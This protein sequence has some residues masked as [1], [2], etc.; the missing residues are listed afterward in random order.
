MS[1]RL[2]AFL[3]AAAAASGQTTH[4]NLNAVLW[5][6]TAAEKR[7]GAVQTYRAAERQLFAAL[8]DPNWTAALEQTGDYQKLPPAVILDLDETVLDNSAIMARFVLEKSAFNEAVWTAWVNERRAPAVP[9]AVDF[10][11]VAHANGVA[12]FYVTN[13]VCDPTKA[14]DPTADVLRALSLPFSPHR[15]FCKT[16]ATDKSARRQRIAGSHR[17]LL[18]IGDDLNDFVSLPPEPATIEARRT[19]AAAHDRY[20]GDRWFVLPNPMYGSW[21][22]AV[23]IEVSKKLEALRP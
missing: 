10:I 7:A 9:G 4:E 11:K 21:E 3:A 12:V 19:L 13:R 5:I 17:V 1:R 16:G 20:W 15:L 22:R 2:L 14:H 6:Q 8:K 18:L 23:G